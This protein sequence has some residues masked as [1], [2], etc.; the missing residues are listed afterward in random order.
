MAV[1][2]KAGNGLFLDL[3]PG[4][5]GVCFYK[6]IIY[7][8]HYLNLTCMFYERLYAS[9][10]KIKMLPPKNVI[11]KNMCCINIDEV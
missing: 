1:F 4:Y 8:W 2:S 11:E 7:P 6:G 10:L 5:E 3:C 9:D